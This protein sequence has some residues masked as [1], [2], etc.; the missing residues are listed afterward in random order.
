L[1]FWVLR[2]ILDAPGMVARFRRW[3]LVVGPVAP[4]VRAG[5]RRR[6]ANVHCPQ[7]SGTPRRAKEKIRKPNGGR[8]N[9]PPSI[10]RATRRNLLR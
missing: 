3:V 7:V 5:C 2:L 8:R 9:S 10:S 4:G 6:L 1:A